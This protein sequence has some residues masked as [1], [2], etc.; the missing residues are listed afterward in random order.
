MQHNLDG[1]GRNMKKCVLF[2]CVVLLLALFSPK[3]GAQSI[4]CS[5]N[6][7]SNTQPS[8]ITT[9][10]QG[11]VIVA[12]FNGPAIEFGHGCVRE[13]I[14][15]VDAADNPNGIAFDGT[16]VW[17]GLEASIYVE[18]R[19]LSGTMDNVYQVGP[20]PRGV[21]FDGTYIWVASYTN[22]TISKIYPATGAILNTVTVGSGPFF[23]AYNGATQTIWVAN[24]NSASVSVVNENGVVVNT[25]ATGSEPEFVAW[26]G[27]T[28][29]FV[30]CY[31]SQLVEQFSSAG[32]LE[33]SYA[34][35][36]HGQPLGIVAIGDTVWGVTHGGY[37]FGIYNGL[38][39]YTDLGGSDY[40]IAYVSQS[41]TLWVTDIT[42]GIVSEVDPPSPN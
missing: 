2:A 24:R 1:R 20:N 38:V 9:D 40:D 28:D 7:G 23:M 18:R 5:Y 10:N 41:N 42:Q 29:M 30:S 32:A 25:I 36:G 33:A 8:G 19:N 31:A 17:A 14:I 15:S 3:L 4:I 22:N 16:Y 39:H 11:H 12:Y 26:S 34:I 6:A 27:G 13:D 21:V 37:L 35:T